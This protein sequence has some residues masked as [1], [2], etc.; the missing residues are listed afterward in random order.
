[1]HASIQHYAGDPEALLASYDALIATV[2]L[3]DFWV[4][5]CLRDDDGIVVV[6]TCPSKEVFEAFVSGEQFR[7]ALARHGLPEPTV[8]DFPVHAGIL[9]GRLEQLR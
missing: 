1:M 4:Q 9:R 7:T 2:P 6:D 5:L 8:Q 3:G